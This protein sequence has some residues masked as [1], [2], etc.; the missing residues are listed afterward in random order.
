MGPGVRSPVKT[1]FTSKLSLAWKGRTDGG[2]YLP[3]DVRVRFGGSHGGVVVLLGGGFQTG[4][5]SLLVEVSLV[6]WPHSHGRTHVRVGRHK[7]VVG[8]SRRSNETWSLLC[9]T[10]LRTLVLV[11]EGSDSL[12]PPR[13]VGLSCVLTDPDLGVNPSTS[14]RV[15]MSGGR[16]GWGIPRTEG[17]HD[18]GRLRSLG[19]RGRPGGDDFDRRDV[20]RGLPGDVGSNPNYRNVFLLF[21]LTIEVVRSCNVFHGGRSVL[22]G[23]IFPLVDRVPRNWRIGG[24]LFKNNEYKSRIPQS[25]IVALDSGYTIRNDVFFW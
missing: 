19:R 11:R 23:V 20:R 17:G 7:A 15:F 5:R 21:S 14:T 10:T 6:P 4:F 13:R 22:L 12:L 25:N 9:P 2:W 18:L 8:P 24:I 1:G 16:G 3:T